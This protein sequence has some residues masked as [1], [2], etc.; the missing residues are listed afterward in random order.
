M[1]TK[2]KTTKRPH[3]GRPPIHPKADKRRTMVRST[4]QEEK[5]WHDAAA[6][7][8]QA[9]G[10]PAGKLTVGPWARTALNAVQKVGLK[11][12]LALVE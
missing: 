3:A 10:L 12:L 2:T 7:D 4:S 11:A 6:R 5:A 8:E 9:L 1:A